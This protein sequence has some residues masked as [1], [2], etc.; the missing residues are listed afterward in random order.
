[1]GILHCDRNP[2]LN[3]SSA[4]FRNPL[5]TWVRG[6]LCVSVNSVNGWI[7]KVTWVLDSGQ[8]VP[9]DICWQ[10]LTLFSSTEN[11]PKPHSVILSVGQADQH[12]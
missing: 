8:A 1:M 9:C 12:L 7:S 5:A 10:V 3:R 2:S 6:S 11:V 4:A